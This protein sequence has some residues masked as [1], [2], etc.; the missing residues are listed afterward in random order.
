[1]T[2][3]PVTLRSPEDLLAVIPHLLGFQPQS[4]I[5]VMGLR[6]RKLGLT[7]RMD[8]PEPVRVEE[9]AE[10]L[11]RHL[12]KDAAEAALLVGYE[13]TAGES[14][15]L[16]D[17]LSEQLVARDVSV[18]DRIVVHGGRW[19]SLDCDQPSCCPPEGRPLPL[20]AEVPFAVAEFIGV[21]SAPLRDREA[22]AGQVE[23]GPAADEVAQLLR[24][25]RPEPTSLTDS[26]GRDRLA[27]TWARLLTTRPGLVTPAD[28]AVALQ[29]LADIRTRDGITW[30]L[31]PDSLDR[32]VL[33]ADTQALVRRVAIIRAARGSNDAAP[34][35]GDVKARLITLCQHATDEHAAPVL[36]VLA[37]CSWWHGDGALARVALDRALRCDP[38]YRLARLLRLMIDEGIRLDRP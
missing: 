38:E 27:H 16:I 36:T 11:V 18:R 19:R 23:P 7:Q 9:V 13:D 14:L 10:A 28:A 26:A 2:A 21:G 12:R 37:T 17:A 35:I 6:N 22:L 30:L 8:L 1:M 4:A 25:E 34:S 31:I 24:R 5:V 33:P 15:T 20:A 29:S 3:P 32:A